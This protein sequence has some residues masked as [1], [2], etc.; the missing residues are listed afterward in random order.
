MSKD[1]YPND[2]GSHDLAHLMFEV[3]R[4]DDAAWGANLTHR[5]WVVPRTQNPFLNSSF[6]WVNGRT[7][8]LHPRVSAAVFKEKI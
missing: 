5:S 7:E 2:R 3:P 4:I 1:A 6:P 8:R